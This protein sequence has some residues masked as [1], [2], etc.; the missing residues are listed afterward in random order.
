MVE[1]LLLLTPPG[2]PFPLIART[3]MCNMCGKKKSPRL[4]PRIGSPKLLGCHS[5]SINTSNNQPF[6][7]A[8]KA[9]DPGMERN[10]MNAFQLFIRREGHLK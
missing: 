4:T 3:R 6:L 2:G 1:K 8:A 9:P 5:Q 7:T 10:P